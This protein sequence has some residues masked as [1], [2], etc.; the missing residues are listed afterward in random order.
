MSTFY[1]KLS[2]LC[3]LLT[4]LFSL[5][6]FS[7]SNQYLDFDGVDDFVSVPNGTATIAG[8]T[9]ITIAGWFY[10]NQ[11]SYGQGLMGFRGTAG[12]FYMIQ[13]NN[14]VIECRL[15]N[16]AGN[17][18]TYNAPALTIVPQVWQHFA[19]VYNGSN[20]SLYRNGVLLGGVAAT[21]S[22]TA[23]NIAFTIGK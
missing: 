18:Y 21:G 13:L 3:V 20:I 6:S 11:L 1:K 23:T 4:V 22:I 17:L 8:S 16:S 12:G 19:W 5:P 2:T 14:G 9:Q 10:D 7:Q 15:L